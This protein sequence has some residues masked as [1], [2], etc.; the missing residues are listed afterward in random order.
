MACGGSASRMVV[1]DE[2]NLIMSVSDDCRQA[3]GTPDPERKVPKNDA[4]LA[5]WSLDQGINN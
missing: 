5:M 4:I 3:V 1:V 2:S